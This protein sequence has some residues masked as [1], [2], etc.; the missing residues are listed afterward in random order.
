MT[1]NM[2]PFMEANNVLEQMI[3]VNTISNN[4]VSSGILIG[5]FI[6]MVVVLLRNNPPQES[7]MA[8]SGICVVVSLLFMI[9]G[10]ISTVW[11]VGFTCIWAFVI[12]AAMLSKQ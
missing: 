3:A 6:V 9:A 4:W 1:Y 10:L 8:A 11:L 12:I 2:T 7:F 5:L